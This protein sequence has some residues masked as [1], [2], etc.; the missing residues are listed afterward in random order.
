MSEIAEIPFL[1]VA[2]LEENAVQLFFESLK[3]IKPYL[4]SPTV[5]EVMINS[6]DN[7]WVEE[8][9]VKRTTSSRL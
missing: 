2:R 6:A 1:K 7:I 5:A 4:E 3:L 9:G 8:R